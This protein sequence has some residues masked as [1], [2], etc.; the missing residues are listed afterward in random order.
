MSKSAE[1]V[2]GGVVEREHAVAD[3]AEEPLA[4]G[5]WIGC[6]FGVGRRLSHGEEEADPYGRQ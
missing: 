3:V 1:P 2:K 5:E 6:T 4:L